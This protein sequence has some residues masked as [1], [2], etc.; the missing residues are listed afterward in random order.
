[1]H[2]EDHS[3]AL[4]NPTYESCH[5]LN[6]QISQHRRG[7][8]ANPSL[9]TSVSITLHPLPDVRHW[10]PAPPSPSFDSAEY[11]LLP[12]H[13]ARAVGVNVATET[14]PE[15]RSWFD[16]L[17]DFFYAW[18]QGDQRVETAATHIEY[19]PMSPLSNVWATIE[20]L[21][22]VAAFLTGLTGLLV[23]FLGLSTAHLAIDGQKAAATPPPPPPSSTLF[24]G[25]VTR[26]A[27]GSKYQ[28]SPGN[29]TVWL[30][31]RVDGWGTALG[32]LLSA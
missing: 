12:G 24:G 5:L 32:R 13:A 9:S 14:F 1:V 30:E 23:A 11:Y 20:A 2:E 25:P 26:I 17:C 28:T 22:I 15:K 7:G 16:A 18:S 3:H 10:P 19:P 8:S 29:N 21:M 27:F 31:V 6:Q 4:Y